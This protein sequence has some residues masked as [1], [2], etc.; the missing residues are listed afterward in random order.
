MTEFVDGPC[1]AAKAMPE[2]KSLQQQLDMLQPLLT[3]IESVGGE[4]C[5][6]MDDFLTVQELIKV[7]IFLFSLV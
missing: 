1:K 2:I 5:V 3:E 6:Q 4:L 7:N